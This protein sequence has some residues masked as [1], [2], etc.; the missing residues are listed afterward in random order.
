MGPADVTG[1]G[2]KERDREKSRAGF[3]DASSDKECG[4]NRS[5]GA[6]RVIKDIENNK[7]LYGENL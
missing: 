1:G 2:Q 6:L 5:R 3:Y 4:I 7:S